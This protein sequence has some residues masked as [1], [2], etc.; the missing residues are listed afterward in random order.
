MSISRVQLLQH[1]PQVHPAY[2]A[3]SERTLD[4]AVRFNIIPP[5][6]RSKLEYYKFPLHA[7][8][9]HPSVTEE[10]LGICADWHVWLWTMDDRLDGGDLEVAL[11]RNT[12]V[13]AIRYLYLTGQTLLT[14]PH[15][16]WLANIRSR[17]NGCDLSL[18]D[19]TV[20]EFMEAVTFPREEDKTNVEAYL[21]YRQ[22]DS[23][24]KT[25]FALIDLFAGTPVETQLQDAQHAQ[26]QHK[27]NLYLSVYND[28]VSYNK[29]KHTAR[30]AWNILPV[31]MASGA[32][33]NE[34]AAITMAIDL[35]NSW[36]KD[37][38]PGVYLDCV[39]GSCHWSLITP[40]YNTTPQVSTFDM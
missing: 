16:L 37:I 13:S 24:C 21:A 19:I 29:E 14:D 4:N 35:L 5:E 38:I 25:V 23:A 1:R 8:M 20:I 34:A 12:L 32:A 7:A 40:R 2:V 30:K 15:L 3:V 36:E 18:F 17:M 6:K 9:V 39:V 27:A 11:N 31:Y 28:I 33:P 26:L 10:Q 22:R